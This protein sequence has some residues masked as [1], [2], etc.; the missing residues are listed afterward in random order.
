[1]F[2]FFGASGVAVAFL[3]VG[4]FVEAE[5][6]DA[7]LLAV[8]RVTFVSAFFAAGLLSFAAKVMLSQIK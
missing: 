2:F 7:A 5:D 8:M 4:F 3:V 1:M 6:D